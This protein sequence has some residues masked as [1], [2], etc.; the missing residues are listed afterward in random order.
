MPFWDAG[1]RAAAVACCVAADEADLSA[2]HRAAFWARGGRAVAAQRENLGNQLEELYATAS[3]LVN[4]VQACVVS[5]S[6][7]QRIFSNAYDA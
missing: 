6:C 4:Y 3:N 2:A 5:C 7:Q 1:T